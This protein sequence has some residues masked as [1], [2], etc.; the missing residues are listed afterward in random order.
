MYFDALHVHPRASRNLSQRRSHRSDRPADLTV[1]WTQP[2]EWVAGKSCA[3]LSCVRAKSSF[4]FQLCSTTKVHSWA[5]YK[6]RL[7]WA[8]LCLPILQTQNWQKHF[9][10]SKQTQRVLL[11]D[12]VLTLAPTNVIQGFFTL[13]RHIISN[14]QGVPKKCTNRTKS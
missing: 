14:I 10:K 3:N 13:M 12:S 2:G 9:D 7:R 5:P 4:L 1:L 8:V 11:A 6:C